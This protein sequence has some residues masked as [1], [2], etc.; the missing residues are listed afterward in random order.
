MLDRLTK[1]LQDHQPRSNTTYVHWALILMLAISFTGWMVYQGV[2]QQVNAQ[3]GLGANFNAPV[4]NEVLLWRSH[5]RIEFQYH[6]NALRPGNPGDVLRVKAVS[7]ADEV[8]LFFYQRQPNDGDII[9]D[10][11]VKGQFDW[12]LSSLPLSFFGKEG[13]NNVTLQAIYINNTDQTSTVVTTRSISVWVPI[14]GGV[15]ST[16]GATDWDKPISQPRQIFGSDQRALALLWRGGKMLPPMSAAGFY[17]NA[18]ANAVYFMDGQTDPKIDIQKDVPWGANGWPI[19]GDYIWSNIGSQFWNRTSGPAV[20]MEFTGY[21]T[22][23]RGTFVGGDKPYTD[24]VSMQ[25]GSFVTWTAPAGNAGPVYPGSTYTLKWTVDPEAK[26]PVGLLADITAS[27]YNQSGIWVNVPVVSGMDAFIGTRAWT[28]PANVKLGSK[29]KFSITTKLGGVQYSVTSSGDLSIS[30]VAAPITLTSPTPIGT[31]P[32]NGVIKPEIVGGQRSFTLTW[33]AGSVPANTLAQISYTL[34]DGSVEGAFVGSVDLA[35]GSY[36]WINP[37]ENV[38]GVGGERGSAYFIGKEA[39]LVFRPINGSFVYTSY[40]V[41]FGGCLTVTQPQLNEVRAGGRYTIRWSYPSAYA[42]ILTTVHANTRYLRISYKALSEPATA[43]KTIV[44]LEPDVITVKDVTKVTSYD[45]AVPSDLVP[46]AQYQF[47]FTWVYN[48][49]ALVGGQTLYAKSSFP[50]ATFMVAGSG[51]LVNFTK[52][53]A[54]EVYPINSSMTTRWTVDP[55]G[56]DLT[57][58]Q[59]T[60]SYETADSLPL[61]TGVITAPGFE[62]PFNPEATDFSATWTVRP[63]LAGR[64]VKIKVEL[65]KTSSY[66]GGSFKSSAFSVISAGRTGG[67]GTQPSDYAAYYT[68]TRYTPPEVA[69]NASLKDLATVGVAGSN[70]TVPGV[71]MHYWVALYNADQQLIKRLPIQSGQSITGDTPADLAATKSFGIEIAF[72]ITQPITLDTRPKVRSVSIAYTTDFA[73]APFMITVGPPTTGTTDDNLQA[74]AEYT[75]NLF[76][77]PNTPEFAGQVTFALASRIDSNGQDAAGKF[78][79]EF[80]PAT[81]DVQTGSVKLRLHSATVGTYTFTVKGTSGEWEAVSPPATLIVQSTSDGETIAQA[82]LNFTAPVQRGPEKDPNLSFTLSLYQGLERL[83]SG[84]TSTDANDQG[85]LTTSPISDTTTLKFN[86]TYTAYIKTPKHLSRKAN[87]DVRFTPPISGDIITV[88]L[89]FPELP[90]GDIMPGSPTEAPTPYGSW[91]KVDSTDWSQ[92]LGEIAQT[93]LTKLAD[94]D[95]SNS[96]DSLDVFPFVGGY[97]HWLESGALRADGIP[98]PP[99]A[100]PAG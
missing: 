5:Y 50:P 49:S 73:T 53:T 48:L 67:D 10:D 99:D 42:D 25:L 54:G 15:I 3:T 44:D 22:D 39:S 75:I 6:Y 31:S 24:A 47:S 68:S 35:S 91:D 74:Y 8:D 19:S 66:D 1:Q 32:D 9:G 72:E 84:T 59:M 95:N 90:A 37:L 93:L 88:A 36:T 43:W 18:K 40:P 87:E 80:I 7:S 82:I 56:W 4:Q 71:T 30:T 79:G 92:F 14:T 21:G 65:N 12:D 17:N 89:T 100:P 16:A 64:L 45:W 57:G 26:P 29:M 13:L 34:K 33:D 51:P 28:I 94:F 76:L 11:L 63:Q 62:V 81:A 46:G 27:Y 78:D 83:Y 55:Q 70:L 97:S 69:G 98:R 96:V 52:P 2:S 41:V 77:S 38:T 60:V 20:G 58:L 85:T 23:G 61:L 86:E